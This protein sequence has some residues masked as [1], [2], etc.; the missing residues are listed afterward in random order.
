MK[1][2]INPHLLTFRRQS[3][4]LDYFFPPS[5]SQQTSLFHILCHYPTSCVSFQSFYRNDSCQ[6]ACTSTRNILLYL[7]M[8][9]KG[10]SL[11]LILIKTLTIHSLYELQTTCKDSINSS[12]RLTALQHC[13]IQGL[14]KFL[15]NCRMDLLTISQPLQVSNRRHGRNN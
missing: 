12:F 7:K 10:Q 3:L 8:P 6:K 1:T 9:T 4:V 13:R 11:M 15:V 14:T 2:F 5:L